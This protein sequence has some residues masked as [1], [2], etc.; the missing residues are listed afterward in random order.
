M[1][2]LLQQLLEAKEREGP[3]VHQLLKY[4]RLL[5]HEGHLEEQGEEFPGQ[6][7][8][9]LAGSR[10]A[11]EHLP[12]AEEH[13]RVHG[14]GLG[15]QPPA[16]EGSSLGKTVPG[17]TLSTLSVLQ[18]PTTVSDMELTGEESCTKEHFFGSRQ[19]LSV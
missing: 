3:C 6:Q 2:T 19:G 12:C 13:K 8:Q 10:L 4:N 1:D 5:V 14:A 16:G 17:H 11:L 7:R 15:R 9:G 18:K